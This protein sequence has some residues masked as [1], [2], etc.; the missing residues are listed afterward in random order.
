MIK[1]L[2]DNGNDDV[3]YRHINETMIYIIVS[4]ISLVVSKGNCWVID[5]ESHIFMVIIL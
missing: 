4:N 1:N 3:E 2:I 5:T